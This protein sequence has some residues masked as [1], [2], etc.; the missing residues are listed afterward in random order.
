MDIEEELGTYKVYPEVSGRIR[1]Y[2]GRE[3][4]PPLYNLEKAAW[5]ALIRFP[6]LQQRE[7]IGIKEIK[8][9]FSELKKAGYEI[10]A[11]SKMNREEAWNYLKEIK[12]DISAMARVYCPETLDEINRENRE[13]LEKLVV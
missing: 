4:Q 11:Y 2:F 5:I 9:R 8:E 10:C 7:K 13:R 12:G 3:N 1:R 6:E